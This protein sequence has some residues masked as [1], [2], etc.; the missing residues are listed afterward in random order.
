MI[1]LI[2]R[3]YGQDKS[4]KYVFRSSED[5]LFE[6]IIFTLKREPGK[7]IVCLSSQAGCGMRCGFCETGK[8]GYCH[9]LSYSDMLQSLE[10]ILNENPDANVRWVSLMGMGEPLHNFDNLRAFYHL[11]KKKYDLTLSLSTCGISPIIRELADSDLKYH[12]FI[13]L[14]FS[15]DATRT[16]HMPVNKLYNIE[17]I[18]DAC[19]Y[20]HE[21]RPDEKIEISYLMLEGIN[22]SQQDLDRLIRLTNKEYFLVQLLFYN[23]GDTAQDTYHRISMEKACTID[24][25][26]K[27]HGVASYLSVSAGQDI[28]GACGQMAAG[29]SERSKQPRQ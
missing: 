18:F 28:G 16:A 4:I 6:A 2:S 29:A 26:L 3:A 9:N 1:S 23:A 8:I 13:S 20:Y 21:K 7:S 24:Q 14:H 22:T 12:L 11:V 27:E 19:A 15:D 17:S 25:Y 5:L 10:C